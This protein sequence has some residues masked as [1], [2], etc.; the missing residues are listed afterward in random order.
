MLVSRIK[1]I[2]LLGCSERM[3]IL[4]RMI[5]LRL[6]IVLCYCLT[7]TSYLTFIG[8][9]SV[10]L[11]SCWM[12]VTRSVRT[13]S[14][15]YDRHACDL[16]CFVLYP[17]HK[18]RLTLSF[19]F[20]LWYISVFMSFHVLSADYV[21]VKLVYFFSFFLCF[22]AVEAFFCTIFLCLHVVSCPVTFC[23]HSGFN[24]FSSC[25]HVGLYFFLV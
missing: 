24:S 17:L 3:S 11:Q 15:H 7:K 25:L 16:M 2:L 19:F 4:T 9:H 1:H 20:W 8:C 12:V 13:P 22:H 23:I 10:Q 18:F 14:W 6:Y 21:F 5:I